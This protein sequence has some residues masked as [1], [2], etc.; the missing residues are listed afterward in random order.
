MTLFVC[1]GADPS[2]RP[3]SSGSIPTSLTEE[4]DMLKDRVVI[5]TLMVQG[6]LSHPKRYHPRDQDSHMEWHDAI[7]AEAFDLSD[8][9]CRAAAARDMHIDN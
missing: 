4:R 7:A 6:M 1:G 9:I 3:C 2:S 5:A 8:A